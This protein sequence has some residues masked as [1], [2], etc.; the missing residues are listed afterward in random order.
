MKFVS[1]FFLFGLTMG[2]VFRSQAPPADQIV[3]LDAQTSG[4]GCPQGTVSTSRSTDGTIITFGFDS[5]QTYIGPNT[6][7]SDH[8][9]NCQIHLNLRYPGG[10]SYAVTEATYHGYAR[11]DQSVTGTFLSTYYFSQNAGQTATTRSN[12]TGPTA[13]GGLVY[14]KSDEIPTVG[15]VWAPCGD[16]GILN[17]NN[18]IAL[19]S[20]NSQATGE[21]SNDDATVAFT[22]QLHISWMPCIM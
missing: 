22:Q 1:S 21:L 18:R 16:N 11:L 9:K 3:V 8:S 14:T 20:T 19:A 7:Q 12:I 5:F 6:K 15:V 17:V 10:F 13:G 4:S 2:L